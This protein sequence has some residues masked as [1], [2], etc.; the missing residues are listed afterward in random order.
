MADRKK[1]IMIGGV[2]ALCIIF[3]GAWLFKT[4]GVRTPVTT[5][6]QQMTTGVVDLQKA[7]KQ[8]ALYGE[9]S[10]L[11]QQQAVLT[12]DLAISRQMVAAV[13]TAPAAD[14]QLFDTAVKQK[15]KLVMIEKN[16][17]LMEQ[18]KAAE[19]KLRAEREAGHLAE[20]TAIDAQYLNE[21]L[22]I[23]IKLDNAD[24]MKLSQESI[25]EL[26]KRL[27]EL[28][29]ARWSEVNKLNQQFEEQIQQ[30]LQKIWQKNAGEMQNTD[31]RS[32]EQ[33]QAEET[34]KQT[35]AQARNAAAMQQSI[36]KDG[37]GK[38]IAEKSAVLAAK[39]L[40]VQA[41]EDRMI[42]DIAGKASKLAVV[43][44]LT[45]IF[46]NPSV[47]ID[48]LDTGMIHIGPRPDHYV[49]VI[50]VNVLDVTDELI[51]ELKESNEMN[52]SSATSDTAKE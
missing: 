25:T 14:S 29:Y 39:N 18:I 31:A 8:H 52:K 12:A 4:Y 23:R 49:S 28:R 46:A 17:Q 47:N 32:T 9:L 1:Q 37:A 21:I 40:E 51:E 11:R 35:S 30:E 36:A 6:Q 5:S 20:K 3:L 50:G 38:T 43:H 19:K 24:S 2:T 16:T 22:N 13:R 33:L 15:N 26:E 48:A 34:A 41:L 7:L 10:Q 44:H 45:L 42:N 27:S